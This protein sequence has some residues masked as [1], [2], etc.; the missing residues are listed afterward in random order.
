MYKFIY[1]IVKRY[2]KEAIPA[3]KEVAWYLDQD[4]A[5][6]KGGIRITP[7]LYIRFLPT[8]ETRDLA[9]GVQEG[10]VRFEM[11]LLTDSLYDNDKRILPPQGQTDHYHLADSIHAKLSGLQGMISDLVEFAA[12]KDTVNDMPVFNSLSREQIESD[13]RN[14]SLLRTVFVYKTHAKDYTATKQ[15]EKVMRELDIEKLVL[16]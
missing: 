10:V 4:S 6:H 12:L 11:I 2:L 16:D 14:R 15:Y 9:G 8:L 7:A 1:L 13:H 5:D 3:L